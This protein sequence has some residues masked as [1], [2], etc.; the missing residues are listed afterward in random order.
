MA[1]LTSHGGSPRLKVPLHRSVSP[2]GKF[3]TKLR[4]LWAQVISSEEKLVLLISKPTSPPQFPQLHQ[5]SEPFPHMPGSTHH[6][7]VYLPPIQPS[8]HFHSWRLSPSCQHPVEPKDNRVLTL[9]YAGFNSLLK[10]RG[11][12][13]RVRSRQ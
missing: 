10:E 13:E 6:I 8:H 9:K 4:S 1:M 7:V 11:R 3:T 12:A 2:M 5:T